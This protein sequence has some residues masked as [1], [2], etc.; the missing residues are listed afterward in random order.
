M[1]I[2]TKY[3]KIGGK[4]L[5]YK[6]FHDGLLSLASVLIIFSATFIIGS[7]FLKSY[8]FLKTQERNFI[9][10]ICSVNIVFCIYYLWEV[11]NLAKV[12]KLEN[13]YIILFGKRIGIIT[14]IYLIPFVLFSSLF[15]RKLRTLE[16]FLISLIFIIEALLVGVVLKEVYDLVFQEETRRDFA[17]EENRKKY[18]QK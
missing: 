18:I 16:I 15:F 8:I 17:M 2:N 14:L 11:I 7:I 6:E 1:I 5:D 3:I 9:V 10:I 4:T 12:F 13:K